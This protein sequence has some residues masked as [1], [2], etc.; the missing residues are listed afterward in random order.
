M[1][2]IPG[3]A[4]GTAEYLNHRLRKLRHKPLLKARNSTSSQVE[5]SRWAVNRRYF[6]RDP[7]DSAQTWHCLQVLGMILRDL[8]SVDRRVDGLKMRLC[9]CVQAPYAHKNAGNQLQIHGNDMCIQKYWSN[10]MHLLQPPFQ[11]RLYL[12]SPLGLI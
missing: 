8:Q 9:S 3:C 6:V 4:L 11:S 2:N 10:L 5:T 1:R 12:N 7:P